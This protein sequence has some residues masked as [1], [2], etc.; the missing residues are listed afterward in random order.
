M[1]S[2]TRYASQKMGS[3]VH[4]KFLNDELD[5]PQG[6]ETQNTVALLKDGAHP[7]ILVE[8]KTVINLIGGFGLMVIYATA[9]IFF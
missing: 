2:C 3:T 6:R 7:E 1:V 4:T 9:S 8:K 5:S